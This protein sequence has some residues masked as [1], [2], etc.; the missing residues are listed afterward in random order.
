MRLYWAKRKR[1]RSTTGQLHLHGFPIGHV[2]GNLR[3][4]AP[5]YEGPAPADD[6]DDND[7][8]VILIKGDIT[9]KRLAMIFMENLD[10][11]HNHPAFSPDSIFDAAQRC[12]P[13]DFL[14]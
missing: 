12:P 2:V 14:K 8:G 9:V 10:I 4:T 1:Q 7:T 3:S 6:A 13:R 5:Q 11:A